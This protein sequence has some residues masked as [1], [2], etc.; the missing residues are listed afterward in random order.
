MLFVPSVFAEA[1][2][3]LNEGDAE[4]K[5]AF[6]LEHGLRADR[7]AAERLL[8]DVH[9]QRR[10]LLDLQQNVEV[11]RMYGYPLADVGRDLLRRRIR[12]TLIPRLEFV[13]FHACA[14]SRS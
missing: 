4:Q 1:A 13:A 10:T 8:A 3:G 7:T 12:S 6:V 11:L 9:L 5:V 14:L 2:G